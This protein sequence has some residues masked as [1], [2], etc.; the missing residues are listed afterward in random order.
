LRRRL[1]LRLRLRLRFRLR[2]NLN[3]NLD[4]SLNLCLVDSGREDR[5]NCFPFIHQ[6]EAIDFHLFAPLI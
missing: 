1:R 2:R 4:L 5:M 6:P 3:L